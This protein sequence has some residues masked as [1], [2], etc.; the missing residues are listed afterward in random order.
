M[1]IE[2]NAFNEYAKNTLRDVYFAN[3]MDSYGQTTS[4]MG[5]SSDLNFAQLET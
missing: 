1:K 4:G 3:P 5:F 2:L